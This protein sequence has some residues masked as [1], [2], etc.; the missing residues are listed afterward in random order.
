MDAP[1]SGKDFVDGIQ[2]CGPGP[3]ALRRSLVIHRDYRDI[4]ALYEVSAALYRTD[5]S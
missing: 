1:L 4:G 2:Y 5:N 3:G